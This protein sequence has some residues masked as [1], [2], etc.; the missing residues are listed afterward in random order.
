MSDSTIAS[1]IK[2]LRNS[3]GWTQPQLAD[4]ISVSKQTISNWETGLKVPRMGAL[5]KLAGIFNV[6]ISEIVSD[7]IENS[8]NQD[9]H[10]PKNFDIR[11][12]GL[13]RK[14]VSD[15]GLSDDEQ[16]KLAKDMDAYLKFRA[17]QLRKDRG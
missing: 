1:Q 12:T 16:V 2:K 15:N 13:F 6:P 14:T 17:E 10:T 5:Q 4:K 7:Q 8:S 9:S 3:R 11:E